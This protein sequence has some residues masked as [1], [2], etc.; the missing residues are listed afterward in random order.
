MAETPNYIM[1]TPGDDEI[2][3]G[4]VTPGVSGGMPGAGADVLIASWGFDTLDAGAGEDGYFGGD[5]TRLMVFHSGAAAGA[6]P[7]TIYK[8]DAAGWFMGAD[9]V[10]HVEFVQGGTLEDTIS[11]GPQDDVLDGGAGADMLDGGAG[12]DRL[13]FRGDPAR[14]VLVDL[15]SGAARDAW[16][17]WDRISRI[18]DAEG[19]RFADMLL[20][21]GGS[22]TL[23]GGAGDDVLDGQ[24]GGDLLAGGSGDD[25][26]SIRHISDR[27]V[28]AADEG[29]D[30]VDVWVSGWAVTPGAAVE[31]LHLRVAGRLS[32]GAGDDRLIA[33]AGAAILDGLGGDDHLTGGAGDDLL[34]GGEGADTLA[35][36]E[37]ADRLEGGAGDDLY[38]IAD[39]RAVATELPGEGSDTALVAVDGWA[40]GANI[41]TLRLTDAAT[42]LDGT[43]A[44][45]TIWANALLGSVVDGRG[46]N[47]VIWG[48]FGGDTLRGGAGDDILLGVAGADALEGGAGDD[49]YVLPDATATV[50]EQPGG[51]RDTAWMLGD[52]D[53]RLAEGVEVGI[54]GGAAR[55]LSGSAGNDILLG[56][57]TLANII[58]GGAGDDQI[59]GGA[60]ADTLSG[61][62]GNDA[63][64]GMGGGDL[65]RGGA[66]DDLYVIGDLRDV[67]WELDGEGTDVALVTTPVWRVSPGIEVVW[68][69]GDGAALLAGE[70]AQILV[71]HAGRASLLEGG[72]GDDTLWG[73]AHAD[74]LAGGAGNDIMVVGGGADRLRF[75]LADWGHDSIFGLGADAVLDF[76]GSGLAS[77]AELR[78][79]DLGGATRLETAAGV[80]DFYASPLPAL[81]E[82]ATL[83]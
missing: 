5:N 3:P 15:G 1:G 77:A 12:R 67:A 64:M 63:F 43:A 65:M 14:G 69:I 6:F 23:W 49:L 71:G 36:G 37:G 79:T 59:Y 56:N 72:G 4:Y 44:G 2:V 19:T 50:T 18:E 41:E 75:D 11:L 13:V 33:E 20:G 55:R 68:L 42:Q 30:R 61:G 46:G 34:R 83:F 70:G 9:L 53:W 7:L 74:V 62:L 76:R 60:L 54:L 52:A 66:G 73:T 81:L 57:G 80:V 22:N 8:F 32:G 39:G 51:G 47:D 28:E 25:H 48:G 21:D 27:V 40:A 29:Q 82:M 10:A 16:G 38:V 78:W 26:Y 58:E 31:A 24:G 35:G 17:F 45:E